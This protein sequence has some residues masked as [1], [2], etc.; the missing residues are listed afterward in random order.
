MVPFSV[1]V[2]AVVTNRVEAAISTST[3][4]MHRKQDFREYLK[5]MRLHRE[6]R[7]KRLH[8]RNHK[9]EIPLE[10]A[11][12]NPFVDSSRI[13][14]DKWQSV[15]HYNWKWK[16]PLKIHYFWGVDFWCAIFCPQRTSSRSTIIITPTITITAIIIIISII[17][18]TTTT[19]IND[20]HCYLLQPPP[21]DELTKYKGGFKEGSGGEEMLEA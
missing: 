14:L 19:T 21:K 9:S 6:D 20:H 5:L 15:G 2:L 10:N 16:T 7:G 12:E 18:V 1:S 8:A 17:T 4:M 11:M 13:P 3:G